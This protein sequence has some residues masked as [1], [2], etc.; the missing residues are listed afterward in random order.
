MRLTMIDKKRS[1]IA[2]FATGCIFAALLAGCSSKSKSAK[3][4]FTDEQLAAFPAPQRNNLPAPSGGLVLA[5][6]NEI[7]KSDEV[8]DAAVIMTS[9]IAKQKSYQEFAQIAAPKVGALVRDRIT[10]ILLYQKALTK[11]PENVLEENGPLDK[12]VDKEIK[13][14]VAGYG[15]DHHKAQKELEKQGF[16]WQT[17]REY[18]KK[19]MLIQSYFADEINRNMPITHS[20]LI[21]LYNQLKEENFKVE[22]SAEFQLIDIKP[23][24][25]EANRP[26]T[27]EEARK[28]AQ[29]V[30]TRAMARE[31]FDALIEKYSQGPKAQIGGKWQTSGSDSLAAPYDAVDRKVAIMKAETTSG[32]LESGEHFFIVKLLKKQSAG[33]IPFE[34]VQQKIEDRVRLMKN[35]QQVDTLVEKLIRQ[36]NISGIEGFLEYCLQ[37]TYMRAING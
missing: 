34:E 7:I 2:V 33:Y 18:K 16:N 35:K 10:N 29:Q 30:A 14:F 3:P 25:E 8:I 32:V 21:S 12:A 19:M 36:A 15:G 17:Y 27:K 9:D 6:N 22:A 11:L 20:D 5:V 4:R 24:P 28:L 37:H 23:V 13:Q 1:F 31:D 26:A